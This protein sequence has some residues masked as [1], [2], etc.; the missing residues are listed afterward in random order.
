MRYVYDTENRF[1]EA[2][3]NR[4]GGEEVARL[5][6]IPSVREIRTDNNFMLVFGHGADEAGAEVTTDGWR[7]SNLCF[8]LQ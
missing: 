3:I 4:K 1:I 6:D 7:Y 2:V 8:Q 5:N